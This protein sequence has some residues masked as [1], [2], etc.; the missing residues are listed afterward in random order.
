MIYTEYNFKNQGNKI[1]YLSGYLFIYISINIISINNVKFTKS[2]KLL[3]LIQNPLVGKNLMQG[4]A[5]ILL[6]PYYYRVIVTYISM[7]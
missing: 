1:L 7:T 5:N 2:K 3:N 4:V 6:N